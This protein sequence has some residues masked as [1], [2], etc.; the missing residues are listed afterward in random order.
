MCRLISAL[1][2]TVFCR[3]YTNVST[4]L[5]FI[6]FQ[7]G[8]IFHYITSEPVLGHTF[9]DS[10]WSFH[11]IYFFYRCAWNGSNC[12]FSPHL[13]VEGSRGVM[14]G[15]RDSGVV[16]KRVRTPFAVLCSLSDKYSWEMNEPLYTPTCGVNSSISP[17]S[18]KSTPLNKPTKIDMPSRNLSLLT[19]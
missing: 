17:P 15:V 5:V 13:I 1:L 19:L 14:V 2:K 8:I 7:E 6:S 18:S 10:S 11:S 4:C 9:F 16:C 12:I 3:Q